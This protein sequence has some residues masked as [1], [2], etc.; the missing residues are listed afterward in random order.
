MIRARTRPDRSGPARSSTV[1]DPEARGT[2]TFRRDIEGLRAIAVLI[3]VLGHFFR[4]P[5]GGYIGVDVFFVI[6]G[7]LITGILLRGERR[8][9]RVSLTAFYGQRARR[10]LPAGTLVLLV[11]VVAAFALWPT[12]RATQT[13]LDSAAAAAFVGNWHL[14]AMGTDY[15]QAADAVSPVQHYWSLA[16]EEQFYIVWPLLLMVLLWVSRRWEAPARRRLLLV[17]LGLVALASLA[18]AAYRQARDPSVAYFDSVGRAWEVAAGAL[19]A[20]GT[21][22]ASRRRPDDGRHRGRL[23]AIGLLGLVAVFAAA[24]TLDTGSS[25]PYPWAL[26]PVLGTVVVIW[27][28]DENGPVARLLGLAP[29]QFA[30]RISYSL[31]LWHFP[32]GIFGAVLLGDSV[33][34]GLVLLMM[35]IGV[36]VL[37]QRWVETPFRAHRA[38][39][40]PL[41]LDVVVAAGVAVLIV[42]MIGVQLKGPALVRSSAAALDAL[43]RSAP[44]RTFPTTGEPQAARLQAMIAQAADATSWPNLSPSADE[45]TAAQ[46]PPQM[47]LAPTGCR[48]DVASPGIPRT[49]EGGTTAATR[50]AV[51]VGDSVA[52]S[53]APTLE[54]ALVPQ[55]W[56]VVSLGYASCPLVAVDVNQRAANSRFPAQC[57]DARQRMLDEVGRLQP[58]LVV[59]SSSEGSL[60]Y[61]DSGATGSA[62]QAEWQR[63]TAATLTALSRLDTD[64]VV[65]GAPPRVD[66]PATCLSRV[67]GPSRCLSHRGELTDEAAAATAAAV[68]ETRASFGQRSVTSVDVRAWFC[69]PDGRCPAFAGDTMLRTDSTHLT[70]RAAQMLGTVFAAAVAP[71]LAE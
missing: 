62:A 54:R 60:L 53:W 15:L 28:R 27:A 5:A 9:G 18:V 1:V 29:L 39:P 67:G 24:F 43:G 40:G 10:I 37:S 36:S 49:C 30:G 38:A 46:A 12:P 57:R 58:D 52:L 66:D 21:S 61:L 17:A 59:V 25:F 63:G 6:S 13:L 11:T 14:I 34:A 65:L 7:Y 19:V 56:R 4:L 8:F 70:M 33:F 48:N 22:T 44:Q 26:V 69:T 42:G 50:T 41:R 2:S 3:V 23:A 47:S 35:S 71:A 16:V 55:G 45:L 20:V 64:V 32:I 31:Y 51:L 68:A